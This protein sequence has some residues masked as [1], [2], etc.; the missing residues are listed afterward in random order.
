MEAVPLTYFL[1]CILEIPNPLDV[2]IIAFILKRVV[3]AGTRPEQA[4]TIV[5]V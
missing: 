2:L 3:Q 4:F 5:C 1:K